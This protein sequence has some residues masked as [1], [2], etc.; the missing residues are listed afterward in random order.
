MH[1]D[2]FQGL[3]LLKNKTD[4]KFD[5]DKIFVILMMI[6]NIVSQYIY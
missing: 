3:K 6:E 1:L 5:F 4:S 2:A